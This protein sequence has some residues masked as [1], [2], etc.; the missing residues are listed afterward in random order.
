MALPACEALN[1][2]ASMLSCCASLT[3]VS[4]GGGGRVAASQPELEGLGE[5]QPVR[6]REREVLARFGRAG[7]AWTGIIP[8]LSER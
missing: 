4:R 1:T 8:D 7:R 2:I 6:A 3:A 5:R